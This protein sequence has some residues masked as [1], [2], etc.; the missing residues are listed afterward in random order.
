[1]KYLDSDSEPGLAVQ[2]IMDDEIVLNENREY[3]IVFSSPEDRPN[4][5]K[6]ENGV[7]WVDWGQY[8]SVSWTLRWLSVGPKWK[9]SFTPSPENIGRVIDWPSKEFSKKMVEYDN[10]RLP[11]SEYIPKVHYLKTTSFEQFNSDS[12]VQ[13]FIDNKYWEKR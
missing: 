5:A 3:V 11:N 1:M 13:K 12:L 2:A 7:T 10:R 9:A 4:N 6:A 8:G